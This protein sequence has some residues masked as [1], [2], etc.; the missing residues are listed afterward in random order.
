MDWMTKLDY[1]FATLL[2]K[3]NTSLLYNKTLTSKVDLHKLAIKLTKLY[4]DDVEKDSILE[5]LKGELADKK[6]KLAN[7]L[8]VLEDG[9]YNDT[10]NMRM[11]ELEENIKELNEKI[12]S[13]EMLTIKKT[14]NWRSLFIFKII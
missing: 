8:R 13:R 12:A 10:T 5:S 14:F 2:F 3:N 1:W 6:K 4:N 7:I 9:I 11:K